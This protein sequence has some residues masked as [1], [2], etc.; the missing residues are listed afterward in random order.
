MS[1]VQYYTL[2]ILSIL[3]T[4][5]SCTTSTTKKEAN[6]SRSPFNP[7]KVETLIRQF[8]QDT[9]LKMKGAFP[10]F[11]E[12]IKEYQWSENQEGIRKYY[13][14]YRTI[15]GSRERTYYF[16]SK[17]SQ[18]I[19]AEDKRIRAAC[20]SLDEVCLNLQQSYYEAGILQQVNAFKD[21]IP[22]GNYPSFDK[23][24][25]EPVLGALD[26]FE[27]ETAKDFLS[28][29]E[30]QDTVS[31]QIGQRIKGEYIFFADA[32]SFVACSDQKRYDVESSALE[33]AYIKQNYDSQAA[34][35]QLIGYY[36]TL[37]NMENR[38]TPHLIVLKLLK[39]EGEPKC[40]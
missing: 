26:A 2:F 4:V 17:N 40:E 11:A 9:S 21:T 25:L 15:N 13:K 1:Q 35:T 7:A 39:M 20:P 14:F 24:E 38:P 8:E 34:L 33:K 6:T 29:Q 23:A 28:L 3:F 18:L 30:E 36:T 31:L 22:A 5:V 16:D 32:A 37:P 19:F 10:N 27:A 12:G